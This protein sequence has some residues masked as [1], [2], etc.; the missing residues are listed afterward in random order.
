MPFGPPPS[1]QID[2]TGNDTYVTLHESY[3]VKGG[4]A[5]VARF[6]TWT[7][8]AGLSV[9][10]P[11]TWGRRRADLRGATLVDTVLPW[12]PFTFVISE[13]EEGG[14]MRVDGLMPEIFSALQSTLNFSVVLTSPEDKEWGVREGG[15]EGEDG[16]VRWTGMIGQGRHEITRFIKVLSDTYYSTVHTVNLQFF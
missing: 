3:R 6:G 8:E 2:S 4:P 12:E 7:E 15:E 11:D 13:E 10:D 9:P 1:L 14:G 5:T 16:G